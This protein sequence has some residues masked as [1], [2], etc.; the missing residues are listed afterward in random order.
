MK[1]MSTFEVHYSLMNF[2]WSMMGIKFSKNWKFQSEIVQA[3]IIFHRLIEICSQ[4]IYTQIIKQT[5]KG[6]FSARKANV[7]KQVNQRKAGENHVK[8]RIFFSKRI[9]KK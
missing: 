9:W 6:G 7:N 8:M 3:T 4:M 1:H 5:N 2:Q